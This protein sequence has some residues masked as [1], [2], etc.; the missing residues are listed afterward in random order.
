MTNKF[1][2]LEDVGTQI[3]GFSII[4]MLMLIFNLVDFV[5]FNN[6]TDIELRLESA[7]FFSLTSTANIWLLHQIL[8]ITGDLLFKKDKKDDLD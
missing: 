4:F 7:V 1:K 8:D 5:I 3:I 2:G 6:L